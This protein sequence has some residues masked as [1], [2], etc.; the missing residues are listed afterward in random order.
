MLMFV[1]MENIS[2]SKLVLFQK[3]VLTNSFIH[4][5]QAPSR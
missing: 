4:K 2:L 3:F 5:I 1:F